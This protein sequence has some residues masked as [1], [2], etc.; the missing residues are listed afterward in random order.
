MAERSNVN[1]RT[2]VSAHY[3]SHCGVIINSNFSCLRTIQFGWTPLHFACGKGHREV[4][5]LLLEAGADVEAEDKVIILC[6]DI[7]EHRREEISILHHV[8]EHEIYSYY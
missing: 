3:F 4:A 8:H 7:C 2:S 1:A 5:D 6:V